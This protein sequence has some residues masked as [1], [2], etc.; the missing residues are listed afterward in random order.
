MGVLRNVWV[1]CAVGDTVCL[2]FN[3]SVPNEMADIQ[4]VSD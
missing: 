3:N 4:Y 1:L 2:S